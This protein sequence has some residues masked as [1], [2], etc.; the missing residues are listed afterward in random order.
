MK[1]VLLVATVQSHIAQFH[2]PLINLLKEK[3]HEVHVAAKDNLAEKNGLKLDEPEKI[4][5]IP[6]DRS[7]LSRNNI[8]AYLKL[9]KIFYKNKYDIVHC[10]TPMGGVV[11]RLAANKYRRNGTKVFYTAHGF[12]FYKGAPKKNW[13]IYYPIEKFLSR[14]TD[15][16]IAISIEDFNTAKE[17]KFKT[18]IEHIHG[19]GANTDKYFLTSNKL[20]QDL[21]LQIGYSKE[22][23]I[24]VCTGELNDNKNQISVL[25]AVPA[26]L[27]TIPNFKLILAGNGPKYTSLQKFITEM[28]LVDCV[29]MTGYVTDLEKY[30]MISDIAVSLSLREG[31]GLNLIEAMLCAK[32]VI[33]S[34]NRGHKELINHLIN[35]L[36]VNPLDSEEL[37]DAI[38]KIYRDQEMKSRMGQNALLHSQKYT[39]E[40]VIEELTKI[41]E[42]NC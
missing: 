8:I 17:K 9:K 19:V 7:P 6:F 40:S 35:G 14:Y 12:H 16:L 10:N 25:R 23:F 42:L 24:C 26:I 32:P 21:R 36:L 4:F 38:I 20:I 3:G 5:N 34:V 28:D 15:K 29:R 37:S 30:V 1:K 41:Y 11:T 22:D 39:R 27:K 18:K 13:I 2:K 31:L 33:G